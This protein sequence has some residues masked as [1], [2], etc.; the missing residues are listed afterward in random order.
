[1]NILY[2]VRKP[3]PLTMYDLRLW[4]LPQS[5]LLALFPPLSSCCLI[6][7]TLLF[8]H[9]NNQLLNLS[10]WTGNHVFVLTFSQSYPHP[11]CLPVLCLC[12]TFPHSF[13][14]P[15]LPDRPSAVTNLTHQA[16]PGSG[17]GL[18][19]V[20][21]LVPLVVVS[22][23]TFLCLVLLLAVLVYWRWVQQHQHLE[24]TFILVAA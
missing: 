20:E 15:C 21:W 5:F 24:A 3:E 8:I 18:G 16:R 23:L 19:R 12:I 7:F 2:D 22:A 17:A 6:N 9:I 11:V 14:H 1:M 4:I 10:V 13:L